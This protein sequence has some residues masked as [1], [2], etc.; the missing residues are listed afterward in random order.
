M[1]LEDTLLQR[2]LKMLESQGKLGEQGSTEVEGGWGLALEKE[3]S[4]FSEGQ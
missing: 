3:E 4:L 1:K 2:D